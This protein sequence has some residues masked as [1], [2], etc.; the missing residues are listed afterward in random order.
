MKYIKYSRDQLERVRDLSF[1]PFRRRV[2]RV[3]RGGNDKSPD[4][5]KL[6]PTVFG[7]ICWSQCTLRASLPIV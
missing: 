7:P 6:V 4:V 2:C 3:Q 1:P 5:L